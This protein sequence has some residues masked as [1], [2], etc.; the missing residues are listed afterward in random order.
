MSKKKLTIEDIERALDDIIIKQG[1]T[2]GP[3]ELVEIATVLDIGESL[4]KANLGTK[5]HPFWIFG[6]KESVQKRIGLFQ[7]QMLNML[8]GDNN[9]NNTSSIHN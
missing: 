3:P 7:R 6:N 2:I 5:E 4:Y 8:K 9:G 1:I